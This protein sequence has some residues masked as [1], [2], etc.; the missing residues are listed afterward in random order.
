MSSDVAHKDCSDLSKLGTGADFLQMM[1]SLSDKSE[2]VVLKWTTSLEEEFTIRSQDVRPLRLCERD[3][4]PEYIMEN[5]SNMIKFTVSVLSE[6]E[7]AVTLEVFR[8]GRF[9]EFE[10]SLL[11]EYFISLHRREERKTIN[12]TSNTE[13][14]LHVYPEDDS[15]TITQ[16]TVQRWME[17]VAASDST[18]E[19]AEYTIGPRLRPE[20]Y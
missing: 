13:I 15:S 18:T 7:A 9:A 6:S 14:R 8:N 2:K 20:N 12:T 17:S 4:E 10:F 1:K 3:I 16:D 19:S 5:F 11:R